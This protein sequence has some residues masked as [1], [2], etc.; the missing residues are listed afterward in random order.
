MRLIEIF[1]EHPRDQGETYFEHLYHAFKCGLLL[2]F[3]SIACITHS[4]IPFVFKNTATNIIRN[5]LYQ[6][7][8]EDKS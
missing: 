4:F 3:A 8:K 6:R 5:V 7:C 1:L 2:S